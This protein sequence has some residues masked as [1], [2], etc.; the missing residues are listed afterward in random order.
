MNPPNVLLQTADLSLGYG[1]RTVLHAVNLVVYAGEFWC[2][3]GPNGEGKTTL[4][5]AI[6]GMLPAA[7]G[8]LW[9]DPEMGRRERM[10][11]VPQRCDINPTLQPRS[12]RHRYQGF[13]SN[14]LQLDLR[15]SGKGMVAWENDITGLFGD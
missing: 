7:S 10:G 14:V 8:H 15:L 1:R 12:S 6:L 13:R 2:F 11:F 5:R 3:L 4:I 9:L